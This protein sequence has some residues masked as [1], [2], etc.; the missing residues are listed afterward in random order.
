[1]EERAFIVGCQRSGTTLLRLILE[2]HS[3]IYCFDETTAYSALASGNH[4]GPGERPLKI[5]KIPRWTEQLDQEV[6]SDF[7]LA[8]T[9]ARFWRPGDKLLYLVR[10]PRD[11]VVSMLRLQAATRSWLEEWGVPILENKIARAEGFARQYQGEIDAMRKSVEPLVAAGALYWKYK[12]EALFRYLALDYPVLTVSYEQLT[13]APQHVLPEVCRFLGCAFEQQLLNHHKLQ[14]RE[15]F[16][17]GLTVGG[18]NPAVAIHTGSVGQAGTMLTP[19]QSL[20]I[21]SIADDTYSRAERAAA[22]GFD[23]GK[24]AAQ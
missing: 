14:H 15:I 9:A 12:T 16:D 6:L 20:L 7:G 21:G 1:M 10:E 4:D 22:A 11:V 24:A 5:F 17:S 18:T 2:C 23:Q 13:S 8:E 19:D 3:Q